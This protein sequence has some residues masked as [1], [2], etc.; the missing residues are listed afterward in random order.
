MSSEAF[1]KD[2]TIMAKTDFDKLLLKSLNYGRNYKNKYS[3][4]DCRYKFFAHFFEPNGWLIIQLKQ[5]SQ[6]ARHTRN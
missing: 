5:L 4:E 6:I 1:L 3:I 2:K